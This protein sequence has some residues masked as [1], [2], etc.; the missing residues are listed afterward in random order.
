MC[1]VLG[2][3]A[4]PDTLQLAHKAQSPACIPKKVLTV[5]NGPVSGNHRLRFFFGLTISS[6]FVN[7]INGA[8]FHLSNTMIV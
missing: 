7:L 2:L 6:N 3:K 1:F 4:K 8:A 5:I